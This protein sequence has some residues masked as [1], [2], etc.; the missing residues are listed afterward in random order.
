MKISYNWLREYINTDYAPV[1]IAE[2]L[3]NIGLEVETIEKF[4]VIKGGLKGLV[5]G[6]IL[7][8]YKHPGANKLSVTKVDI[9]NGILLNI[10]CG[11]SNVA[12]NQKVVVATIGTT[13]YKND[14][15]FEIKK[16]KI[17]GIE[18][19]GMIC[20]E[21]EIGLS[22]LHYGIMILSE[23][24]VQG[25]PLREFFKIKDDYIFEID[26]TPNRIDAASHYGVARDLAAY[27]QH[28][29][30]VV[31]EKPSVEKF[32]VQTPIFK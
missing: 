13:L 7:E 29:K 20:A 27:L 3:T 22:N 4:E 1:K 8:C 12:V 31:L 6:K 10:V 11:A 16:I 19:E 9:G 2:I 5:V 28:H 25:T 30:P 18:S 26:L 15:K 32:V 23:D 14:D 21:D 17:R 24:A